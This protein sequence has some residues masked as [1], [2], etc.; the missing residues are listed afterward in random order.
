MSDATPVPAAPRRRLLLWLATLAVPVA[1]FGVAE[2][3]T[4]LAFPAAGADDAYL[5]LV[6]VP[7]FFAEKRIRGRRYHVV[8]HPEAYRGRRILFPAEKDPGTFRIF[9]LGESASAGWP[10]PPTEIFSVYLEQALGRAFPER[11]FEVINVSAHAY[12]AYRIR[13]I[14][15]NVIRFEPDALVLWTGNNEF[16]ERRSYLR[17]SPLATRAIALASRS[18]FFRLLRARVAAAFLPQNSLSAQHREHALD[19]MKARLRQEVVSLRADPAQL[20][21]VKRHYAASVESMVG[22]AER[23]GVPMVLV[24]VPVN[25]RDWRPNVS[26]Q[27]LVGAELARWQGEFDAG[28]AA[29]LRA[30]ADE[31]VRRLERA[32]ALSPDHAGSHFALARALE[33]RGEWERAFAAYERACD[34]DGNPF[35]ALSDFDRALREIAGRHAN[36]MIADVAGAFRAASAPRAPGFDLFLDYVH[37]TKA[38]N[39]V[40][41]RGVF[42]VLVAAGLLGPPTGEKG[43]RHEPAPFY[44]DGSPYDESRDPRMQTILFSLMGV[45]HQHEAMLDVARRLAASGGPTLPVVGRVLEVFPPYLELER[46]R[47]LGQPVDPEE[48]RAIEARFED[49]YRMQRDAAGGSAGDPGQGDAS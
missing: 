47:L 6:D 22:D 20:E 42:E 19:D 30:E 39:L 15:E 4:R 34:L 37:P 46:R 40:V 17:A 24:T 44:A 21:S 26:I 38:G 43:F 31:A 13:L 3:G 32:V 41:A 45:M 25:L 23:A 33:A 36:A 11:R 18:A 27:P 8:T 35:R 14:F 29:L 1:V 5:N 9:V 7:S 48:A 28:R 10:H 2:L 49:F 16:L 12:A